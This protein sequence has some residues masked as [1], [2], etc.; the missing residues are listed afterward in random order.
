MAEEDRMVKME[1]DY[2]DTVSKVIPE[3]E[4]LASENK[5]NEAID[6]L[7]VLEKQTRA[8]N[9]LFFIYFYSF[10]FNEFPKFSG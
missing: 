1:V 3:C 7:L 6:K 2:S 10:H 5:L 4:T 8:V 9:F